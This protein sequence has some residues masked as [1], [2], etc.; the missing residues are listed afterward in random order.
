[1][2]NDIG[3]LLT[4]V[5]SPDKPTPSA[6]R[7]YLKKF[8]SDPRVVEI[9]KI[10]WWPIL[11]GFILRTRPTQSAKLYQQI[12]TDQG[13]PLWVF[14]KSLV[15]KLQQKL[16]MPIEIGLHYGDPSIESALQKLNNQNIKKLILLPLYPQYS[17]TTTASTIDKVN[18][19]FKK[20]R[21]IPEICSIHSYAD[22]AHYINA[23]CDSIKPFSIK[24]LLF[25]FHGIPKNYV[26][27]GDPY[28]EQCH[29]TVELI[30]KKLNL[31]K[32][33][34][35]ISFQSRIGK[36]KW[37]MPYTD[38]ILKELPQKGVTDL[39]VICPGFSV[40]CLETL[41]EINIRGKKQFFASGGKSF[42]YIPA[43]ND[44]ELQL[45]VLSALIKTYTVKE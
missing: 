45:E 24:H 35:S 7:D 2:E 15:S 5:G 14:S 8:L 11:Y 27:K 1:M 16:S 29:K 40:D 31:S 44:S 20:W 37:L 43:L 38:K 4:N 12:W 33:N 3:V 13:S 34:F 17:G 23:L 26:D 42:Q 32:N 39:H 21:R 19:I 6:V 22:N 30:A 28:L 36:A 25:S 41:E 18:H 10:I 9:P